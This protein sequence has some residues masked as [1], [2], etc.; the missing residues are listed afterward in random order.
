MCNF[1]SAS[2]QNSSREKKKAQTSMELVLNI[3]KVPISLNRVLRL[4]WAKRRKLQKQWDKQVWACFF[5]LEPHLRQQFSGKVE[6]HLEYHFRSSQVRDMD[7]FT[8]KIIL[9]ALKNQH[10]IRDD[11]ERW[12]TSDWKIITGSDREYTVIIIREIGTDDDE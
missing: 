9:D 7:N 1:L 10:I 6:I 8:P 11:S 12:C 5:H 3:P 4:H 2:K